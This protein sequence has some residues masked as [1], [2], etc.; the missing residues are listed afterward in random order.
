MKEAPVLSLSAEE[1]CHWATLNPVNAELLSRLPSLN[2]HQCHLT[3]GCLFQA[4]WNRRSGQP[5][6]SG[7]K[8]YDVFYFDASD[9][10]WEAEDAVIQR[11][12]LLCADMGVTVEVKNQARVHV[13]YER[14]FGSPYPQLTSAR[15][16]IDRYLVSCTSVGIDVASGELY[17]PNGL[18][19]LHDGV[20]RSNPRNQPPNRFEQKAR[21]YQA[22]WPWL[23]IVPADS[24]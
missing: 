17:A 23:T 2:L 14:H 10:S 16:G 1:F 19:D 13:W 11:V 20:L 3:A 18:Q 21:N 6:G 9:I 4:I 12:Q 7:V 22:R 24:A 5:A 8:D 15:D